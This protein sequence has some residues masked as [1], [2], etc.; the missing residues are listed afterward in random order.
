MLVR[1]V[2]CVRLL[3]WGLVGISGCDTNFCLSRVPV[4]VI[5]GTVFQ[6]GQL[7]PTG[8]PLPLSVA[9]LV[10]NSSFGGRAIWNP[11]ALSPRF[12]RQI[13]DQCQKRSSPDA[14]K[15]GPEKRWGNM[16]PSRL[17]ESTLGERLVDRTVNKHL[18]HTHSA[19]HQVR[20]GQGCLFVPR[21]HSDFIKSSEVTRALGKT[22]LC[23]VGEE[24]DL[25]DPLLNLY[26]GQ[27]WL[28]PRDNARRG[29]AGASV[30]VSL[31]PH[32]LFPSAGRGLEIRVKVRKQG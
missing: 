5:H 11:E 30:G 3:P 29:P 1:G 10:S 20:L 25:S 16:F 24:I 19:E 17:R 22:V 14:V 28:R 27:W 6:G 18:P 4:L 13:D 15:V 7:L 32:I 21:S 9:S 31:S 23:V 26:S 8:P 2:I 12:H